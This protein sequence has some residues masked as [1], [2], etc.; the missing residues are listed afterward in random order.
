MHLWTVDHPAGAPASARSPHGANGGALL[1][2]TPGAALAPR[3]RPGVVFP[4][5]PGPSAQLAADG[6]SDRRSVPRRRGS[7]ADT[8]GFVHRPTEEEAMRAVVM[9]ETGDPDVLRVED[10]ERPEPGD[11]EVLIR[12]HAASVNPIDW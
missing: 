11:G 3:Q 12:I 7:G 1:T 8:V 6:T 10:A 9:R 5:D 4:A 2:G